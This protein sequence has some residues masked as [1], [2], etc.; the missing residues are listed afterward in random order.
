MNGEIAEVLV[1]NV[2][3]DDRNLLIEEKKMK[4]KY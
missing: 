2:S 3:L 4:N 1:W